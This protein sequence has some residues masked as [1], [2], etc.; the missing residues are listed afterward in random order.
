MYRCPNR[1]III[2]PVKVNTIRNDTFG[3]VDMTIKQFA[4]TSVACLL[5][6]GVTSAYAAMNVPL[7]S[8]SVNGGSAKVA[9]VPLTALNPD[10]YYDI[11]CTL[12]DPTGDKMPV[13]LKVE[14]VNFGFISGDVGATID[15]KSIRTGQFQLSDIKPHVVAIWQIQPT[16]SGIDNQKP[17]LRLSWIAGDD[18]DTP[19]S[20]SC[21]ATPS[22]GANNGIK[23]HN[24]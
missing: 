9:D 16:S 4:Y 15:G 19:V 2:V 1:R 21:V 3:E 23:A 10:Y 24:K 5:M 8:G 11:S 18:V 14:L 20:Y 12:N 6:L 17:S 13:K 7:G 22:I